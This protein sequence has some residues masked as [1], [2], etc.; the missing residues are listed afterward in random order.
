MLGHEIHDDLISKSIEK[1]LKNLKKK[2]YGL[3]P[4]ISNTKYLSPYGDDYIEPNHFGTD[5]LDNPYSNPTLFPN[6][7]KAIKY[8]DRI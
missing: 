6:L 8:S 3:T 4:K 2:A 5:V 7:K 1:D